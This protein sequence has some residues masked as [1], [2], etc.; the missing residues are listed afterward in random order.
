MPERSSQKGEDAYHP[1]DNRRPTAVARKRLLADAR[2]GTT[3]ALTLHYGNRVHDDGR[4][5]GGS[6]RIDVRMI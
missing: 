6:W 4:G 2:R 3:M 5:M 1:N